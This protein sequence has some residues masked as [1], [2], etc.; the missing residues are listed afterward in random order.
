MSKRTWRWKQKPISNFRQLAS[1]QYSTP[2]NNLP[3]LPLDQYEELDVK[4]AV[5][6]L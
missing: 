3:I 4:Q 6:L 1:G 5:T 2:P